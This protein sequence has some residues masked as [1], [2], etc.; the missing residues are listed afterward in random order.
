MLYYN[1]AL[2]VSSGPGN[3]VSKIIYSIMDNVQDVL[4]PDAISIYD[5]IT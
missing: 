5:L 2:I 4:N 3:G 1:S